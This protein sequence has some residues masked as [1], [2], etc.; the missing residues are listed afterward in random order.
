MYDVHHFRKITANTNTSRSCCK[1]LLPGKELVFHQLSSIF[2]GYRFVTVGNTNWQYLRKRLIPLN[3]RNY[4]SSVTEHDS[5]DYLKIFPK[6]L[7]KVLK[8][9]IELYYDNTSYFGTFR[10]DHITVK[11]IEIKLSKLPVCI[12]SNFV[13]DQSLKKHRNYCWDNNLYPS[14][15]VITPT[16]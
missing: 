1:R 15:T 9:T 10:H 11:S 13:I 7:N 8:F 2:I 3:A 4:V 14:Y 6:I 5:L 12:T 16:I